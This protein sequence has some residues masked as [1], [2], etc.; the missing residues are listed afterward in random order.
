MSDPNV[1]NQTLSD[2]CSSKNLPKLGV[3]LPSCSNAPI[4][5]FCSNTTLPPELAQ[6]PSILAILKKG[7]T[8]WSRIV[9]WSWCDYL[10]FK[11]EPQRAQEEQDLKVFLHKGLT[12][13]AKYADGYLCYGD[14][15]SQTQADVWSK[16]IVYLLLGKD[17]DEALQLAQGETVDP[18]KKKKV[19]LSDVLCK[20][21]QEP[22]VTSI[23]E[24][25]SFVKLFYVRIIRNAFTG[26][27]ERASDECLTLSSCTQYVNIIAYPP[28]PALD[29]PTFIEK[30]GEPETQCTF[31][32]LLELWASNQIGEGEYLPPSAYIPIATT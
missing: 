25:E 31:P 11:D 13:Q 1:P 17:C 6:E 9:A 20:T 22:L 32:E 18:E 7:V 30:P 19:T 5:G 24:N 2:E 8:Q 14:E 4:P 21:T 23:P 29:I 10:A 15:Q 28:R 3:T 27:V 12:E 26:R 16:V